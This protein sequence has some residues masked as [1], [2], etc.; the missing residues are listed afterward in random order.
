M[1]PFRKMDIGDLV[2]ALHARDT[3]R[4]IAG[5]SYRR[6]SDPDAVVV[7]GYAADQL[8]KLGGLA[9]QGAAQALVV[10]M[11]GD[12]KA[13]VRAAAASALA[14]MRPLW[15]ADAVQ[16]F[17]AATLDSDARVRGAAVLCLGSSCQ[18]EVVP[19]LLDM[20]VDS[21]A[22]VRRIVIAALGRFQEVAGVR[23]AIRKAAQDPSVEVRIVAQNVEEGRDELR[24]LGGGI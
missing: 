16:A 14:V 17:Q 5:L 20:S 2:E 18:S 15:S 10:A 4:L 1:W 11:R 21:D 22:Y 23:E 8:K 19:R 3:K 13:H 12:E 24:P 9:G 7:R 6:A